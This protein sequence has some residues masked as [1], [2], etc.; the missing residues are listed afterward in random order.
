MT[1]VGLIELGPYI[2]PALGLLGV[3]IASRLTSRASREANIFESYDELTA[4][5]KERA[6]SEHDARLKAEEEAKRERSRA[7][8]A[9][10]R[11]READ[12]RAKRC[13]RLLG[14]LFGET[15]KKE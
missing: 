11:A 2:A 9:E 8:E 14:D 13:E 15:D 12:A 3:L 1:S 7:R 6:N 4:H 5:W 10:M